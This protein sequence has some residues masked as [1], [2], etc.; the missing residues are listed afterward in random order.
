MLHLDTPYLSK[1]HWAVQC[2]VR[3]LEVV[4]SYV[5]LRFVGAE[6]EAF[7]ADGTEV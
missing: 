2:F 6:E 7:T 1:R 5:A 4:H 3:T